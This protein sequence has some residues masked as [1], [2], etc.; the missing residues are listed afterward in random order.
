MAAGSDGRRA[1]TAHVNM[2]TDT[3][4]TN[5]SAE[6]LRVVLRSLLASHP[7]V[8]STFEAE[9]KTYI[10]DVALPKISKQASKPD[11][12]ALKDTQK[13]IRCMLGCGLSHES[14][15]LMSKLA[16]QGADLLQSSEP[17][18]GVEDFLAS[19]DGDIVQLVTAVEKT[20]SSA[21]RT[22]LLDE[23]K[24]ILNGLHKSLIDC[25][26]A[27]GG[28]QLEYPYTRALTATCILL[29][30]PAPE[31]VNLA[32]VDA[33]LHS[34]PP[35][36]KETFELNGRKL[37][38]IFSGLWQMSSPSWGS[39]PTS[40]IIAQFSRYVRAGMV[41]FDMADHY[42]DA[43]I[44]F[45]RF[46]YLYPLK[47]VTFAGT[48]YCVFSPMKVTREAVQ[49]NVS[50][51]CRRLQTEKVDLLQFH[52]QFYDDSQYL[53]ALRFLAEDERVSTL[54]LC[55]FDTKHLEA[56]LDNGIKVYSNQV[57]FSLIDSRPVVR[58]AK[59][60]EQHD[61]KLLTYGTLC[62]GFLAE[63]WLGKDEPDLYA[64]SITPSQRKYYA[65]IRSWGGWTLFQELLR[66]L[67]TIASKHHV[68]VSTVAIRWVLD[69]PYVGAVI[70]GAR[71]G[72]SEHTD[73][74]TASLGWSLDENDRASI[75][76]VLKRS[77]RLEM[78]E[79]MGDC[80]GEYR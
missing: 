2:M 75:E 54:G 34:A 35:V 29:G 67:K 57:Q 53:D 26:T 28:N 69:F 43:E 58:M 21:G 42:G 74:N 4:I 3:I 44:V 12:S 78:F 48:K 63:K 45:G 15:T 73:E 22:Q 59:V 80:G 47:G 27:T 31:T 72:I 16:V 13:T 41:A 6:G 65:M 71:M 46:N 32:S 5:I 52:W 37:P 40:K 50:E 76:E 39:A 56:V 38:R 9:T 23:E 79:D 77:S 68:S 70:V 20:L 11:I 30:I 8:T 64:E 1:K 19:V 62:G 17:V 36:A 18:D 25:K 51:R 33:D 61:V 60:C 7:D 10:Q 49:A 24:S 66:V 55:N 14:I